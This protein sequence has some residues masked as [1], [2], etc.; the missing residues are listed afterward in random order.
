MRKAKT[1]NVFLQNLPG[2]SSL[3][4]FFLNTAGRRPAFLQAVVCK[5][6]ELRLP[7]TSWERRHLGLASQ[8]GQEGPQASSMWVHQLTNCQEVLS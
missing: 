1:I 2:T 5:G 4:S 6:T 8:R 3:T 7:Q